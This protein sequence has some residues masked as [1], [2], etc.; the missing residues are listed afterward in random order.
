MYKN[1]SHTYKLLLYYID[2]TTTKSL[3]ICGVLVAILHATL[4]LI[5][6][7]ILGRMWNVAALSG[8][9]DRCQKRL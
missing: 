4:A 7:Y 6:A 1:L 8:V 3:F 9:A 5:L 2:N